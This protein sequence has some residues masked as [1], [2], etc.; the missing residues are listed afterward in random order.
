MISVTCRTNV[1][2]IVESAVGFIAKHGTR[3]FLVDPLANFS[4]PILTTIQKVI[5]LQTIYR[6]AFNKCIGSYSTFC[7]TTTRYSNRFMLT[8]FLL[9]HLQTFHHDGEQ[10]HSVSDTIKPI[11]VFTFIE[12]CCGSNRKSIFLN[13]Q[14]CTQK[15]HG[16]ARCTGPQ[17][18]DFVKEGDSSP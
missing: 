11:N 14:T 6:I 8:N 18:P 9:S 15:S 13:M 4:S 10:F 12:R 3:C 17:N 1:T 16:T 7:S 2:Y 5:P